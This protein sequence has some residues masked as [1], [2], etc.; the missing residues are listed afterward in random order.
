MG[1]EYLNIKMAGV[2]LDLPPH[3]LPSD[4]W[5]YCRNVR[6]SDGSTEQVRGWSAVFGTPNTA[7]QW[8]LPIPVGASYYWIYAGATA[9]GVTDM[10][11]HYDITPTAGVTADLDTNWNGGVLNGVAVLTNGYDAPIWWSNS[12][13]SPMTTLTGWPTGSTCEII[14][15]YKNFLIAL[16]MDTSGGLFTDMVKW[17]DQADPGTIPAS[18]DETDPALDAGEHTL[19][20]SPGEITAGKQLGEDFYIYKFESVYR[21]RYIAGRYIFSFVKVFD[22]FGA[23]NQD[24]VVS[25]NHQ[26]LV[27][28]DGD[29]MLHD[30]NTAKSILDG[31]TRETLFKIIDPLYISR[32]FMV[33]Y[34]EKNEIWICVPSAGS[35]ANVALVWNYAENQFSI[36]DIP[37]CR[38]MV[39]GI[40]SAT[41]ALDW[42]S[43]SEAWNDDAT[44]WNETVYSPLKDAI[45][46]ADNTDTNL[47]QIDV[48]DLFDDATFEAYVERLSFPMFS[49]SNLYLL[50]SV[51]PKITA[52]DGTVLTFR[53]GSQMMPS[54][55]VAWSNSKTFTVGTDEHVDILVKGRYLS[56]KVK[57]TGGVF[58]RLHSLDVE[59][60]EAERY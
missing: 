22:T 20:D 31:V 27:L 17:S 58:W 38:H 57:V 33:P 28:G 53:F 44:Y 51:W 10:T 54:D 4:V 25:V 39:N 7:P 40:I 13:G 43:D 50:K 24:C 42:D 36:R 6:F 34:Y 52:T 14:Q 23:I 9:I 2:N 55:P 46:V 21:M 45:I 15:P 49:L 3:E 26:H 37:P 30:G 1:L 47:F 35:L 19:S 29:V 16:N 12:T 18:W 48:S 60:I 56:V 32:S 8:L 59:A 41:E 11:N 5:S